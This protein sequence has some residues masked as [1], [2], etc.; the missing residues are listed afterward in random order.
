MGACL[1]WCPGDC[2]APEQEA[3]KVEECVERLHRVCLYVPTCT[4]WFFGNHNTCA[5]TYNRVITCAHMH[6]HMHMHVHCHICTCLVCYIEGFMVC[7]LVH[8]HYCD[9]MYA[10]TCILHMDMHIK[11]MSC[12]LEGFMVCI[13]AHVHIVTTCTTHGHAHSVC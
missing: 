11:Y 6:M 1:C 9:H 13:L 7:M 8:V 12:V 4:R 10:H 3:K 2:K 5:C